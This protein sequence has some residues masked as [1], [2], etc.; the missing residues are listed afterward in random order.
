M[1]KPSL[2]DPVRAG[3]NTHATGPETRDARGS[4]A[5][6]IAGV[7]LERIENKSTPKPGASPFS[8]AYTKRR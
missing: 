1:V 6:G 7:M 2:A 5:A 4:R 8:T 3:C